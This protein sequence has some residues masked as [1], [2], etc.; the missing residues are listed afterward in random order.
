QILK[1]INLGSDRK[2]VILEGKDSK[3]LSNPVTG[4]ISL[5]N[6]APIKGDALKDADEAT[7]TA[8]ASNVVEKAINFKASRFFRWSAQ[9]ISRGTSKAYSNLNASKVALFAGGALLAFGA[10]WFYTNPSACQTQLKAFQKAATH[11]SRIAKA[12]LSFR[13]YI[14]F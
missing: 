11:D 4:S 7:T 13:A 5:K 8:F 6:W 14:R 9:S 3:F 1:P 10:Y 2:V 12:W